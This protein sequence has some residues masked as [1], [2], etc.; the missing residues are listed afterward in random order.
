MA[1]NPGELAIQLMMRLDALPSIWPACGR[2]KLTGELQRDRWAINEKRVGRLMQ[3]MA[4]EAIDAQPG[5]SHGVGQEIQSQLLL[6]NDLS[7]PD[8]A[9]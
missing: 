2:P 1:R 4:L 6:C 8:Q 9:R 7:S 5:T 3:M